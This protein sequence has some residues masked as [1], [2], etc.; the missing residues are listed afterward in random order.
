MS[1]NLSSCT[2]VLI[3]KSKEW[4]T[5]GTKRLWFSDG[6]WPHID[7]SLLKICVCMYVARCRLCV[8]GIRSALSCVTGVYSAPAYYYRNRAGSGI[9][10]SYVLTVNL[11]SGQQSPDYW[12]KRATAILLNLSD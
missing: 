12:I 3:V 8:K 5:L 6:A 10:P 9:K 11:K 7:P 2:G 4:V 1:V